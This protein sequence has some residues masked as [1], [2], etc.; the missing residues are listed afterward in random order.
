MSNEI[1]KGLR[2][3][4]KEVLAVVEGEREP[5]SETRLRG[6]IRVEEKENGETVWTLKDAAAEL[7]NTDLSG[8]QTPAELLKAVRTILCQSQ[9]GMSEILGIPKSTY[10]N[11]EQGRVQ[12]KG[13]SISL[14][15]MVINNSYELMKASVSTRDLNALGA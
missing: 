12:P 7:R 15:K 13:P 11:W 4:L 6:F 2:D 10:V 8:H 1:N 3:S 9:T 5:T 14:I